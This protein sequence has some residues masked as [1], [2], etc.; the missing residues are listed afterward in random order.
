[1]YVKTQ[2]TAHVAGVSCRCSI[3]Y[4][5][6]RNTR[7]ADARHALFALGLYKYSQRESASLD[8]DILGRFLYR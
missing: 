2:C 8:S 5:T 3:I 4:L 7:A 6:K 1:M